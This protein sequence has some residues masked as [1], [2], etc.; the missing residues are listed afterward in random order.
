MRPFPWHSVLRHINRI[1]KAIYGAAYRKSYK[2]V[3]D[4]G[5]LRKRRIYRIPLLEEFQEAMQRLAQAVAN[6][7]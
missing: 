4:G 6:I 1:L 2:S 7:A 5:R 3:Y